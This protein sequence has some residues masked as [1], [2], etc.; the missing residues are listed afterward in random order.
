MCSLDLLKLF[1][2]ATDGDSDRFL[3]VLIRRFATNG[4]VTTSLIDMS[5]IDKGSDPKTMFETCTSSL[6]KTECLGKIAAPI[7]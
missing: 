2:L 3:S 4:L 1:G 5:D 6:K 7:L